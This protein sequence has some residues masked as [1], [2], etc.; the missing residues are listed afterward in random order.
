M[1]PLPQLTEKKLAINVTARI[2]RVLI[3]MIPPF[4][5]PVGM[6]PVVE[7]SSLR[8][9]FQRTGLWRHHSIDAFSK[10]N[11]ALKMGFV[12]QIKL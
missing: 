3:R 1:T 11:Y 6:T 7:Q 4:P 2:L 12:R 5:K 10:Y 9:K 8:G